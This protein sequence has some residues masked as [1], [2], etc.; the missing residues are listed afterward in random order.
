MEVAPNHISIL[1]ASQSERY[2]LAFVN[3]C[4]PFGEVRFGIRQLKPPIPTGRRCFVGSAAKILM[5]PAGAD[6]WATGPGPWAKGPGP[7]GPGPCA[8]RP[9]PLG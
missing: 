9:G 2:A 8:T 5:K 1:V 7:R 6:L 4:C 3:S